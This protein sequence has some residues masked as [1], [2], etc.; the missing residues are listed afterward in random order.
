VFFHVVKTSI[1]KTN[2]FQGLITFLSS[3]SKQRGDSQSVKWATE[4]IQNGHG[5]WERG[6]LAAKRR[7]AAALLE[8]PKAFPSGGP[9]GLSR[10]SQL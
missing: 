10:E 3:L 4:G 7:K 5:L 6:A 1:Q 9:W 2:S 8:R